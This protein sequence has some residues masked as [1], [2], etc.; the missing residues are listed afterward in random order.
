LD[1]TILCPSDCPVDSPLMVQWPLIITD[2]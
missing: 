2:E 1:I